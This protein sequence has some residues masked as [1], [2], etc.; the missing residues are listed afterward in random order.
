VPVFL[1]GLATLVFML[2]ELLPSV[3]CCVFLGLGS[4]AG[5]SVALLFFVFLL[6]YRG[7]SL[8]QGTSSFPLGYLS[9][10]VLLRLRSF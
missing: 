1:T 4:S 10:R 5:V 6:C 8:E 7:A 3:S 2:L 9:S